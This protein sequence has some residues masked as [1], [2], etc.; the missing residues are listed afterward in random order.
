MN[1]RNRKPLFLV[2]TSTLALALAG[3]GIAY[4]QEPAGDGMQPASGLEEVI[5]T[6][7]K[8]EESVQDI[9]VNVSAM[10]EQQIRENDL[11]SLEK[12]AA[13]T[14]NLN[15]G[16]ASN[17]S[18]AQ[19]TLRGI[20]TSSTSIGIEQSVAVIVDGA[21]YG[22]G[23][24]INEGFFDMARLELLKG[25]QAL[26]FGKNAT[27]GVVSMTTADPG[28]ETEFLVRGYYEFEAEQVVGEFIASVPI[29]DTFGFRVAVRGSKM[30]GGY[31]ENV[32][33]PFNYPTFDI[34]TGMLN[35]HTATP[36]S[37]ESPGEEEFLGR[38]TLK[39]TPSD[40][41]TAT[42]K[43]M[44]DQNEINNSS[45]D[46]SCFASPTGVSALTGYPCNGGFVTHQ[47]DFPLDIAAN[48]PVAKKDGSEFNDYKSKAVTF[49]LN[50]EL[51]DVTWTW[52]NNWN[53]NDNEWAC[54]CDFQ[55]SP[56]TVFATEDAVWDAV[57]TEL[58]MLTTLDGPF[59]V[60]L[61]GY[62]QDTKREFDQYIAFA[63]IE[64]SSQSPANRYIATSKTSQTDGKTWSL[65]GQ[66]IWTLTDTVELTAGVR[67]TDEKKD[68]IFSQPYNNAAVTFIFRPAEAPG[69]VVT[70]AQKFTNWSPEATLSWKATDDVMTY[71]AYKTGYKSGG[72]SNSGINSGFSPD[73]L[74]DLTFDEE[75][76]K[77]FE[78]GIK[79]TLADN[80]LRL[81]V[82]AY[83]Y[84]YE[85][86]QVDFFRSDIFAFNTITADAVTKGFE[87]QMEFAPNTVP[88]L[89]LH[90]EIDYN[91]SRYDK[92]AVPCY[93]G[94][95]P[96]AGCTLNVGGVPYQDVDGKPTA[97]APDWAGII[98]GR[99][100]ASV[101][102]GMYM[103]I[104]ADARYS[105]SY[106][107]SGFAH[108]LSKIDSY[109]YFDA[110]IRFGSNNGRWEVALIGKN[111]GDEFYVN[112][113]VDGPS[114]G[115]G[116]GTPDGVLADQLGF[117]NL[118]RTIALEA[119]FRF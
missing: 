45:W 63:N 4:A 95:A 93:A 16:R 40:A 80:Q 77:G 101:G 21:Y 34:A 24:V 60:M 47:A 114:T 48:F 50:Y 58:R 71:V 39:W 49:N 108:P 59:N 82:N 98:G 30:N 23:R 12:L 66:I 109:W 102:T 100:E 112:G 61:G 86:L 2:V 7:R 92:S 53:T 89:I 84:K 64:D 105:D 28:E 116:T 38:V 17:G 41:L 1:G 87:V 6:A 18:G 29:S 36:A 119:T 118:P 57:S 42:L 35:S 8:R 33:E 56:I 104:A 115:G 10:T 81:N 111:L 22:Q 85:D 88:G 91:K 117:G 107:A 20:G 26:F 83:R 37:K 27:A 69:G 113:V 76:A 52:V 5:V 51:D 110:S 74:A 78:A 25:P 3:V 44:L 94:Q 106:L 68:S 9:P 14:P 70:A 43:F 99:Y 79:S 32:M 46:Y 73:P 31:Y 15:V 72:F 67:Y 54:N 90:G 97:I 65:F 13:S 103:A 11:T 75:K 62:Y 96:A 19:I 55:A